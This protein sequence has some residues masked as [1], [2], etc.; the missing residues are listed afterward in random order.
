MEPFY[1]QDSKQV[2][3][4]DLNR[5]II[6]PVRTFNAAFLE[7]FGDYTGRL[8]PSGEEPRLVEQ[9]LAAYWQEREKRSKARSTAGSNERELRTASLRAALGTLP[10]SDKSKQ[11]EAME[12]RI[13]GL[14]DR[15]P[16]LYEDALPALERL[17]RRY[18]LAIISNGRRERLLIRVAHSGLAPFFPENRLFT[19]AA[20]GRGKPHLDVYRRA[21]NGMKVTPEAAV[22]V[23]DSWKNDIKGALSI[24]M[25]AIWLRYGASDAKPIVKGAGRWQVITISTLTQLADG[26]T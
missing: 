8:S 5:T 10:L 2:I 18:S 23:G 17:A 26:L 7:A 9:A 24:G 16:Q 11:A 25:S 12:S 20:D 6:D 1:P 21:L 4:F 22:M 14:A 13:R 3:F 15:H 19:P